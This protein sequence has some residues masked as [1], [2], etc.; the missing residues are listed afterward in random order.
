MLQRDF[1]KTN[2]LQTDLKRKTP[3]SH[4]QVAGVAFKERENNDSL[5]SVH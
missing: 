3:Y 5:A 1:K 2:Q 4:A